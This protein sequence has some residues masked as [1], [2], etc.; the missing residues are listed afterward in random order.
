MNKDI[1]FKIPENFLEPKNIKEIIKDINYS[2]EQQNDDLKEKNLAFTNGKYQ[3]R[4][5]YIFNNIEKSFSNEPFKC[6]RITRSPLWTFV[7][8]YRTDYDLLYILLKKDRF[9]DIKK[10][11]KAK[12]H[13]SK[14]LNLPNSISFNT[15][16]YDQISFIPDF[17]RPITEYIFEEFENML[18]NIKDKIKGCI[19][20][21]FLEN[22][23]GVTEI[24]G[25]MADYN[26]DIIKSCN[27]SEYISADIGNITDTASILE[28]DVPSIPLK[29]RTK[30][31]NK[32]KSEELVK[33]RKIKKL[34]PE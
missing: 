4:W 1:N 5:N 12:E 34:K 9:Y 15:G 21:L 19:N 30:G 25:V 32:D 33:N 20:I 14:I 11:A 29:I 17:K 31:N 2:R 22:Q 10:N 23:E 16:I 13:Y 8:I 7:A 3:D 18:P 6:C 28:E 26:L 24:S 27:W